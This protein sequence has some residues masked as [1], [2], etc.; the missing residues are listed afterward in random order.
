[1]N[2]VLPVVM[3]CLLHVAYTSKFLVLNDVHLNILS[4][5]TELPMTGQ[6]TNQ[7]LFNE[8]VNKAYDMMVE[9]GE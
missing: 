6:M 1:M 7:A 2:A 3:S 8:M 4:S 9:S 5:S